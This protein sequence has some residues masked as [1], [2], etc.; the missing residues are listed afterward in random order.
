MKRPKVLIFKVGGTILLL[1]L[2]AFL[3]EVLYFTRVY[4]ETVGLPTEEYDL[5]MIYSGS[6]HIKKTMQMALLEHVPLFE[7]G[8]G[9]PSQDLSEAQNLLGKFKVYVDPRAKTTDQNARY[10][11]PYL[12][13]KGYR[14]V[15]LLNG[16]EQLP[17]ALFL[18][19]LYLIGSNVSIIPCAYSPAPKDWWNYEEA[20]VQIFKFWG[21]LG[22][23]ALHWIGV[24][25]WPPPEWMP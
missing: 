2:A 8:A 7:S 18:T 19:R 15:L 25:D 1:I 20:W 12:R 3:A 23:I 14:R 5:V 9:E 24:D 11:A 21:S 17:R 22:R 13:Q 16:W 6:N 4:A 10:S